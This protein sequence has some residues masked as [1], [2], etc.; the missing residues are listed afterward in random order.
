MTTLNPREP[1]TSA[2]GRGFSGLSERHGRLL[3]L[4]AKRL[5][6]IPAVLLVVSILTFWLIQVVPG[7]PGRSVLGQYATASQVRAWDV[8][9]G[10]TGSTLGRYLH[11]L[12]G[13]VTGHWGNS[14]VFS[15]PARGLVVGHLLNSMLLGIF[16]FVMMVPFSIL[17][18]TIQA[19]REGR[20][21]DRAITISLMS[22]SAVPEFV[23]GVLLLIVFAVW[24]HIVPV[25]AGSDATGDI[26]QRLHAML[27]P[28]IA[29]ALSYIAVLTR[30]V[31]TGTAG[32]ITAPYYRTAALKG[33][34]TGEI[35]RRHMLRN[36]LVPTL[37]LLGLYLGALL[38]GNA[39]VETLFNYPGLGALLVNAAEH[40]DVVLL[41]DGVMVTGVVALLALLLADVCLILMDPRIRFDNT[42]I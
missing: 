14:F 24:I 6:Q 34:K 20:R 38:G 31:R 37:S 17:L 32:V 11:W 1:A 35:V 9:N 19:Y 21:T 28:A 3:T 5:I 22:L 36:A 12:H 40:K 25:S 15:E 10:L 18:G 29:L 30:M 4:L 23:L 42:D 8:S 16:A 27:V 7:D 2:P 41:T 39:V 13:F 33:M 26:F